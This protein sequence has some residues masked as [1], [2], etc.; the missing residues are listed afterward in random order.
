MTV[1]S[2]V[3]HSLETF[4]GFFS[5]QLTVASLVTLLVG[6]LTIL[7]LILKAKLAPPFDLYQPVN[8]KARF[9]NDRDR[10]LVAIMEE[11]QHKTINFEG[12]MATCDPELV[13]E[14]IPKP[15][16]SKPRSI[17][18]RILANVLPYSDGLL[19]SANENWEKQH[20]MLT[21]IFQ[22]GNFER[23]S[24]VSM[25]QAEAVC[26]LMAPNSPYAES[27]ERHRQRMRNIEDS[28]GPRVAPYAP[29]EWKHEPVGV[30]GA[31]DLWTT[32]RYCAVRF[33]AYWGYG[34]DPESKLGRLLARQ[35]D[36][37]SRVSI[38]ILMTLQSILDVCLFAEKLKYYLKLRA[39]GKDIRDSV[40][41]LCEQQLYLEDP[42]N[43]GRSRGGGAYPN[44]VSTMV[45]QGQSVEEIAS[46]INHIQ[47][48]HK[49]IALATALTLFELEKTPTY[50]AAVKNELGR[51]FNDNDRLPSSKN[52]NSDDLPV[53]HNVFREAV[54]L[55]PVT[56]AVTR[57]TG[58]PIAYQ[59]KTI[60]KDT[61]IAV[62]I[63]A[64]HQHRDFW[65]EPQTFDPSRWEN[66]PQRNT[67]IPFLEGTRKCAGYS[68]A[69]MEFLCMMYV[70]LTKN[71]V[72]VYREDITKAANMFTGIEESIPYT[73][74]QE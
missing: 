13:K 31:Y 40:A 59:G 9:E 36:W 14:I 5:W 56:M 41:T 74:N 55:H 61:E 39:V 21:P 29:E 11:S 20:R 37:Y 23:L 35:T 22:S 27:V 70:F 46:Q 28:N 52:M 68:L 58:E 10:A 19:F 49:A 8:G 54:R 42:H 26:N 48:A 38:D 67:Y 43:P 71:N 12:I 1:F 44:F 66:R 50:K 63:Q 24:K 64:L 3:Q 57:K 72:K 62:W 2:V 51:K 53:T 25:D 6:A 15:V 47:G 60:P 65:N 17:L 16:H 45:E 69:H 7:V 33:V 34:L 73:L 4:C 30:D 18:Y 32:L